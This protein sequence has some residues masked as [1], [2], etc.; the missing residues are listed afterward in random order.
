[1]DG[2]PGAVVVRGVTES[3]ATERL[4]WNWVCVLPPGRLLQGQTLLPRDAQPCSVGCGGS[5]PTKALIFCP[6]GW[7]GGL[8]A[9]VS[10]AAPPTLFF[11]ISQAASVAR[12]KLGSDH[13]TAW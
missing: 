4:D 9:W 11:L 13:N 10:L 8:V 3:D 5:G 2:R 7:H 6:L 12:P 1:M